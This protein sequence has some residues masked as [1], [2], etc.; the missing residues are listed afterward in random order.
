MI[1]HD[2]G[3]PSAEVPTYCGHEQS[4]VDFVQRIHLSSEFAEGVLGNKPLVNRI[5]GLIRS[6]NGRLMDKFAFDHVGVGV[7]AIEEARSADRLDDHPASEVAVLMQ[8]CL[9][10]FRTVDYISMRRTGQLGMAANDLLALKIAEYM[11]WGY[12]SERFDRLKKDDV[13]LRHFNEISIKMNSSSNE[14]LNWYSKKIGPINTALGANMYVRK[15]LDEA[16]PI[17][18]Q[19]TRALSRDNDALFDRLK[20][21]Q[22]YAVKSAVCPSATPGVNEWLV[23]S[24]QE[25]TASQTINGLPDA[26]TTLRL[27]DSVATFI[28]TTGVFKTS[29]PE[30]KPIIEGKNDSITGY[31][32]A[33][34][35]E[36]T[37][38]GSSLGSI[39]LGNDGH[40][41]LQ[42]GGDLRRLC[43][44]AGLEGAYEQLRCEIISIYFDL[45]VPVEVQAIVKQELE[46]QSA[47]EDV[48]DTAVSE[49]K[50]KRPSVLR[51][52]VLARKRVIDVLGQEIDELIQKEH[53]ASTVDTEGRTDTAK[54]KVVGHIRRLPATY[55]AGI[56]ARQQCIEDLGV[57]LADYGET[58]VREHERGVGEANSPGHR[59]VYA[60]GAMATTMARKRSGHG[61]FKGKRTK[62]KHSR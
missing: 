39:L 7:V 2:S 35:L 37:E 4:I 57:V 14:T 47:D 25:E 24:P 33:D 44:D 58:Y 51:R 27:S 12:I 50:P 34:L 30:V 56:D 15:V 48:S 60:A 42:F 22:R 23:S 55:R 62:G 6:Q 1:D 26:F 3:L 31:L 43:Q 54:H 17:D 5:G 8:T 49:V 52:L 61:L 10:V 59:V 16:D 41:R 18:E 53:Q 9:S 45:V 11:T 36:D 19:E 29:K 20:G 32:I 40:V 28:G 13:P 46:V 38:H 21:L